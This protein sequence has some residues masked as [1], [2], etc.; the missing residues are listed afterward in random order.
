MLIPLILAIEK[1]F[2]RVVDDDGCYEPVVWT[3]HNREHVVDKGIVWEVYSER[4][5][6]WQVE[7]ACEADQPALNLFHGFNGERFDEEFYETLAYLSR[8]ETDEFGERA[9]DTVMEEQYRR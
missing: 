7:Y 6:R 9:V 8:S 5:L 2:P 1:H 4:D 3:N